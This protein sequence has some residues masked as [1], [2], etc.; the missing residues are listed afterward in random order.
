M[1][2]HCAFGSR[3]LQPQRGILRPANNTGLLPVQAGGVLLAWEAADGTLYIVEGHHRLALARRNNVP[4]MAV[5]VLRE[6]DGV[7]ASD[8][9]AQGAMS[10]IK[11]GKKPQKIL[12]KKTKKTKL[13]Q[14]LC[15]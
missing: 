14:L 8:A 10:N 2:R 1:G 15:D 7:T 11:A 12:Q 9:R 3:L 4:T 13:F 6:K 5:K